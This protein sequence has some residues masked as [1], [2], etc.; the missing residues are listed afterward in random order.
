M[1]ECDSCGPIEFVLV[2]GYD[3]GDRILEGV[4]FELRR[5][6]SH[7]KARVVSE[8]CA[9]MA[10]MGGE[11]KWL[12]EVEAY[13]HEMDVAQCPHCNSEVPVNSLPKR[14]PHVGQCTTLPKTTPKTIIDSDSHE[15]MKSF[16]EFLHSEWRSQIGFGRAWDLMHLVYSKQM[17]I[18][19]MISM[20]LNEMEG[21]APQYEG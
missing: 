13:A 4:K 19:E 1:F 2:D 9:Y 20:A 5:D 21:L 10:R 16:I 6:E 18:D 7:F 8:S 11:E 17:S 14:T 12:K 15:R 3:V